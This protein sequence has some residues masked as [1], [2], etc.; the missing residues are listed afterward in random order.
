MTLLARTLAQF[1]VRVNDI[2]ARF[3]FKLKLFL[4]CCNPILKFVLFIKEVCYDCFFLGALDQR[5][6]KLFNFLLERCYK[7]ITITITT[8]QSLKYKLIKLDFF[9]VSNVIFTNN[10]TLCKSLNR[11]HLILFELG[12]L[13]HRAFVKC[14]LIPI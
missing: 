7:L 1:T 4:K 2:T 9:I 8:G 3:A 11:I 14:T 13:V 5:V 6:F 10:H 12:S